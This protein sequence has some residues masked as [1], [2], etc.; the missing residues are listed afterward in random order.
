MVYYE[1][2]SEGA[3]RQQEQWAGDHV[4]GQLLLGFAK[5]T[6]E[7]EARR[8]VESRGGTL[9]KWYGASGGGLIKINNPSENIEEDIK[10]FSAGPSVR[11]AERNAR[12][13][14]M[15]GPVGHQ[16]QQP[17][18]EDRPGDPV[19]MP[20]PGTWP[21]KNTQYLPIKDR[22]GRPIINPDYDPAKDA[23]GN[24]LPNSR[25]VRGPDGNIIPRPDYDP[26]K[27]AK[28]I[29]PD[30]RQP[31]LG[32]PPNPSVSPEEIEKAKQDKQEHYDERQNIGAPPEPTPEPTPEPEPEPLP[33]QPAGAGEGYRQQEQNKAANTNRIKGWQDDLGRLQNLLNVPEST[34][35]AAG[36]KSDVAIRQEMAALNEQIKQ[37]QEFVDQQ[38][39]S[40]VDPAPAPA[41]AQQQPQQT[42]QQQQQQAF[43]QQQS[44]L[45]AGLTHQDWAAQG[46]ADIG[47]PDRGLPGSQ[48]SMMDLWG[49]GGQQAPTQQWG[50]QQGW[51]MQQQ[52]QTF[53]DPITGRTLDRRT[54]K[55]VEQSSQKQFGWSDLPE[56]IRNSPEMVA[57]RDFSSINKHSRFTEDQVYSIMKSYG[58]GGH[59]HNRTIQSAGHG[60][61]EWQ[62]EE[63]QARQR[64]MNQWER[65]RDDERTRRLRQSVKP[66]Q[67]AQQYTQQIRQQ[68]GPQQQ[69]EAAN[70]YSY[71][72]LQ[73]QHPD[74]FGMVQPGQQSPG[75]GA[76]GMSYPGGP[77]SMFP[78]VTMP[79][80]ATLP[81][82]NLVGQPQQPLD[83]GFGT[84]QPGQ[85]VP[86]AGVIPGLPPVAPIPG[87]APELGQYGQ[88]VTEA[89]TSKLQQAPQ[90][91]VPSGS[92]VVYPSSQPIAPTTRQGGGNRRGGGGAT[93]FSYGVKVR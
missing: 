42:H 19:T 88:E 78:G 51:Q 73:Q 15:G 23:D 85:N 45:P 6:T 25:M 26:T 47:L 50:G 67:Q 8:I 9:D 41:P 27:N 29:T 54:A 72:Q 64:G 92:P 14:P 63:R 43:Q 84:G 48:P 52:G 16:Q 22:D 39:S 37:T 83:P 68:W 21:P 4:K 62:R 57:W 87:A 35:V 40:A 81:D 53:R 46:F 32:A 31:P 33:D 18:T 71:N 89:A 5:G 7:A 34:R 91:G 60:E 36:G 61:R 79:E 90:S 80:W 77:G 44:H 12:V 10:K 75:G 56:H 11:Y 38:P 66:Q 24:A 70:R 86:G 93:P 82:S 20:G 59:H 69:R 17:K 3:K 65:D 1:P 58:P 76:P 49:G 13:Y 30:T 2:G 55:P 28:G 74:L